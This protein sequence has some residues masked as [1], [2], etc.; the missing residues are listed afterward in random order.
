[1][2]PIRGRSV[3]WS[4]FFG[5][6]GRLFDCRLLL[7]GI[8]WQVAHFGVQPDAVVKA[9]D[10]VGDISHGLGV[11]CVV[12]LPNPLRLE[13]REE[14]FNQQLPLPRMPPRKPWP[15]SSACAARWRTGCPYPDEQL[16][17]AR[18]VTA[19]WLLAPIQN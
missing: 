3:C 17:Q 14:A 15:A 8:G 4:S 13:A 7:E 11:V 6:N 19:R 9:R 10:V 18:V 5:H 12:A 2:S 1:M 16:G